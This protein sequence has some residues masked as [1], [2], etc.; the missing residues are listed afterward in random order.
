MRKLSVNHKKTYRRSIK[1]GKHHGN[2]EQNM[3]ENLIEVEAEKIHKLLGIRSMFL[4]CL[5]VMNLSDPVALS[6]IAVARKQLRPGTARELSPTNGSRR[7]RQV[8]W[9]RILILRTPA[10]FSTSQAGTRTAKSIL[11]W[12]GE[13]L[14]R[15]LPIN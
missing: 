5:E 11:K 15:E 1:L 3:V 10:K 7:R 9:S 6:L 8:E 12:P 4:Y 14:R 2:V 13:I